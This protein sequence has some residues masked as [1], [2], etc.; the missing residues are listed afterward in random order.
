ME[1]FCD[2]CGSRFETEGCDCCPSCGAPFAQDSE[3]KNA[4]AQEK[5]LHELRMKEQELRLIEAELNSFSEKRSKTKKSTVMTVTFVVF[6][7]TFFIVTFSVIGGIRSN[8]NVNISGIKEAASRIKENIPKT[9][10]TEEADVPV[11]VSFNETAETVKYSV[12]CDSFEKIDRYPFTPDDGYMYVTFHFRIKNTGIGKLNPPSSFYCSVN[13]E[14]C[15]KT[16]DS[17]RREPPMGT[18][19]AGVSTS[20]NICFEVPVDAESFDIRYGDY[21][22][23]HIDN[24]L[25]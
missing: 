1:I 16:W 6:F 13:G 17:E 12:I 8:I 25:E 5:Q 11:T 3:M 24:T 9:T 10:V 20:G 19:P 23:I 18:L 4:A 21:V 15:S 22:T 7:I 2:Y 14:I